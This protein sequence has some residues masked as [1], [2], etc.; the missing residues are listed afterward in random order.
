MKYWELQLN[1]TAA[2]KFQGDWKMHKNFMFKI[3][4]IATYRFDH[5]HLN[6][7]PLT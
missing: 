5:V 4:Q 1:C 6:T 2:Q 7:H 3:F